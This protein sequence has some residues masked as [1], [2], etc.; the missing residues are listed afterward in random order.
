MELVLQI[1]ADKEDRNKLLLN[2]AG[3][4]GLV[5][6]AFRWL[7]NEPAGA[8]QWSIGFAITD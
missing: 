5:S 3:M 8:R 2:L 1:L 7:R 6:Q 4:N